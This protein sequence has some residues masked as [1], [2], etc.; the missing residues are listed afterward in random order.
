MILL[1]AVDFGTPSWH[2][3]EDD[4][5]I[6]PVRFHGFE[7]LNASKGARVQSAEFTCFGHKWSLAIFPGGD[8][9][10]RDGMVGVF[11]VNMSEEIIE[12]EYGFNLKTSADG[13]MSNCV[14][15]IYKEQFPENHTIA[16]DPNFAKRTDILSEL[17]AGA[18]II[19]LRMR[20]TD[21]SPPTTPVPF[22]P[23][24][25]FCNRVLEMFMDD[26]C[27]DVV[28]DIEDE[29]QTHIKFHAH[30]VIF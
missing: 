16:G 1:P 8:T 18:L 27:A 15:K 26:E 9:D 14:G 19:E 30:R 17:V 2:F 6:A 24:N 10:S 22:I 11:L 29:Q 13:Y 3:K 5:V 21:L 7:G 4:W 25:P 20:R 28:F 12:V 23:E